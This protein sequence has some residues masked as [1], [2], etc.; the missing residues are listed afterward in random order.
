MFLEVLTIAFA[1]GAGFGLGELGLAPKGT[2][3]KGS[4]IVL[5][6]VAF[7]ALLFLW[8]QAG[9]SFSVPAASLERIVGTKALRRS[10]IL[11]KKRRWQ[12]V[13]TFISIPLVAWI[14][15]ATFE[16]VIGQLLWRFYQ[17]QHYGVTGAQFYSAA[18]FVTQF[19]VATVSS[20]ILPIFLTVS[21][22]D[23]RVRSEG[24]DLEKMMEA[25]G[26]TA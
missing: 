18:A 2:A 17:G 26:W 20:A 19:V 16:F 21:Y 25:A 14:S 23:Q 22:Y 7:G 10:W 1:I 15:A 4:L 3:S 5:A 9:L 8:I 11:T 6:L 12:I 13:L 24:F